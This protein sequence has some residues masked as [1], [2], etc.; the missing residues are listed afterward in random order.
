MYLIWY[1]YT[2]GKALYTEY[3]KS[4]FTLAEALEIKAQL[5][6]DTSVISVKLE[7]I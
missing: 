4:E 3:F 1:W 2:F 5:E 6:R 7:Q